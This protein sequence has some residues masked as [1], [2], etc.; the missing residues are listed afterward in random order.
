MQEKGAAP[1]IVVDGLTVVLVLT[2]WALGV[3]SVTLFV[4]RILNQRQIERRERTTRTARL[5]SNGRQDRVGL[6][7]SPSDTEHNTLARIG[8]RLHWLRGQCWSTF[9]AMTQARFT[10]RVLHKH[11]TPQR[12]VIGHAPR[13]M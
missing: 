7:G 9:L 10:V 13:S 4:C 1:L 6:G 8:E 12:L 5:P 11:P 3:F 2:L